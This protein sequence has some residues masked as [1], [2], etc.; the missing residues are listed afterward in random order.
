MEISPTPAGGAAAASSSSSTP[1]PST[2][3]PATTLRL[4][5]PSS[6]AAALRHSRDLHVDQPPVGDGAVLTI[7]GPDAPAAAV[8]A[9]ERVVGHR[10]GG[11][12]AG[13]GE[14]EREVSGAVGCRMLAAGGQVGCVLGKGRKT[15]ERMR[16]ESGAQ[17][18]VFRNRE[19]LPPCAAPGDELIHW[20]LFS[21]MESTASSFN[22]PPAPR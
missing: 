5:C 11:D 14:E 20:E 2:K 18:W 9:W 12:E 3:R 1:S 15:V 10:V 4:L 21:S 8:R 16:Q 6:R 17:I 7:S 19:Q 22:L 13:D